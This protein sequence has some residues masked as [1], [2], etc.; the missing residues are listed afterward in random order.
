[1]TANGEVGQS[2]S[3]TITATGTAPITFGASGLA[4]GLSRS[5]AVISGTP[6]AAGTFNVTITAANTAG[7]A[8]KTLVLVVAANP[9]ADTDGMPDTWETANFGSSSATNGAPQ[10]DADGDGM[11][12]LAEYIAGTSPTN[13]ADLLKIADVVPGGSSGTGMVI[14][15][16]SVAGKWYAI[17]TATNLLVGFDGEAK[18][19]IPATP[20]MNTYTVLVDQIRNRYYGDG[21][22]REISAKF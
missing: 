15:W 6:S 4:S 13:A 19:N 14:R 18:T 22:A 11:C 3:Y 21:G 17:R 9:D 10:F 20:A 1:L 12:N 8:T 16:S 7:T 5:G 2:F